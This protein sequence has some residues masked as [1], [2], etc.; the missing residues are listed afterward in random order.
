MKHRM[1]TADTI[2]A[3]ASATGGA[4]TILRI[5]GP[6]ALEIGREVWH[7]TAELGPANL[8]KMLL[9]TVAGEPALA[10]YMR[11]PRSYTGDDVVEL[12]CHGGSAAASAALRL[13]LDAGCRM[14]EPG[15]FTFRAFV[16]GKLDL[17]QAEAVADLVGAGS[18]AARRLAAGQL[19]GGLSRRI[20]ALCDT[21]TSLRS[22]CEAH[23]DFPDE[24]LDLS[25]TNI[26]EKCIELRGEVESLLRT[27]D[28]GTALRSGVPV[29][30]AGA[31]NAGKS[32]LLNRLLGR[33]RAI[34]SDIP[35]TTRDVIEAPLALRGFPVI[36]SD[37]AGLRESADPLERSGVE[38]TLAALD[39]AR[40]IFYLLDAGAPDPD[41]EA[42]GAELRRTP[43]MIA[44]WN[45]I[46]LVPERELPDLPG[47]PTV[48][49]SV[50]TGAGMEGFLDAFEAEL[51][52]GESGELP[53]VAV[54]ERSAN[55]LRTARE[56]LLRTEGCVLRAEYE[57]AA[58]ELAVAGHALGLVIGR[59]ADPDLLD[60]VFR[61]FCIGK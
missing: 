24:E 14:A 34:V 61:N 49:I 31:P 25:G 20:A 40:V 45:K 33:D 55:E 8:R 59:D 10:V 38:R 32:S 18:E 37:T 11:A 43:G 21:V 4:I 48:R 19:A 36:L 29:V 3:P 27:A 5:A 6:R 39:G 58:A 12:H 54:N 50:L 53:P 41:A 35:G 7:G 17:A 42:A 22:E 15:E 16:N 13:L 30:L 23:L 60:E 1:N 51:R 47:I 57:L 44:V 52:H 9:G 26:A 28:I 46:D 56:S 2:A